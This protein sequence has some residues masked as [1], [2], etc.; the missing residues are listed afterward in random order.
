MQVFYVR[1][2]RVMGRNGFIVDKAEPLTSAELVG[3][4]VQRQRLDKDAA[5]TILCAIEVWTVH[6]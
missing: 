5:N 1:K 2:G 6:Q 4:N 3:R